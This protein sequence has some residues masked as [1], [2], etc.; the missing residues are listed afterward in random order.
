M[1][2][3]DELE[4]AFNKK[5]MEDNGKSLKDMLKEKREITEKVIDS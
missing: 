3:F 4:E 1:R 5:P 2:E